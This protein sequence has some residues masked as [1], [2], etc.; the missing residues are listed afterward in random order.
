MKVFLISKFTFRSKAAWRNKQ[1]LKK[2]H[3][4]IVDKGSI[5]E[6]QIQ[7]FCLICP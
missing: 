2:E 7:N 5:A 6:K 1:V 3:G 4:I